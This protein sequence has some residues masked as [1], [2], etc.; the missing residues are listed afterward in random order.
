MFLTQASNGLLQINW[1]CHQSHSRA[2]SFTSAHLEKSVLLQSVFLATSS[3]HF[4]NIVI[5]ETEVVDNLTELELKESYKKKTESG[6]QLCVR[7][8]VGHFEN[9]VANPCF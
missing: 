8:N 5:S 2:N 6:H 9:K 7:S 4:V 1:R 3:K